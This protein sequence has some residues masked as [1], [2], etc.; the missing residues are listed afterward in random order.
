MTYA[1]AKNSNFKIKLDQVPNY[2][3]G[4][5]I[6]ERLIKLFKVKNR[7]ELADLLGMH[8]GSLSTWQTRNTTPHELLIRIHLATGISMNYLCFG[9]S[10]GEQDPYKYSASK[11]VD[12]QDGLVLKESVVGKNP[13]RLDVFEI[14]DGEMSSVDKYFA[15]DEFLKCLGLEG[16]NGDLAIKSGNH[17]LFINASKTSVNAGRYLFSIGDVYQLGTFKLLPDG[18][19]YLFDDGDKYR[20]DQNT[21][22][23]HGKVVSILETI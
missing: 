7:L 4:K 3:G 18:H 2:D 22:K 13:T 17:L 8:P 23:I 21:T 11:T 12:Y 5:D 16:E 1:Q 6:V 19:V 9:I 10:D 20:V 14:D 15:D